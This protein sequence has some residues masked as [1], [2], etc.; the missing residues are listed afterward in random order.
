M[1]YCSDMT[2]AGPFRPHVSLAAAPIPRRWDVT[3]PSIPPYRNATVDSPCRLTTTTV[4]FFFFLIFYA[5][6]PRLNFQWLIHL[7][8]LG[9]EFFPWQIP[10]SASAGI[11]D[12]MEN[13]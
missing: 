10:T 1:P 7:I 8:S 12:W 13:V 3:R 2:L 11:W 5:D 9:V 6:R 4:S